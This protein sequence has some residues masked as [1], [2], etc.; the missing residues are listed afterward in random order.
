MYVEA[1]NWAHIN[2]L[3]Q[4][5]PNPTAKESNRTAEALKWLLQEI[6]NDRNIQ[7]H[8]KEV[9]ANCFTTGA[10]RP[11]RLLAYSVL[12]AAAGSHRVSWGSLF[13]P[14]MTDLSTASD[15]ELQVK[16]AQLMQLLPGEDLIEALSNHEDLFD[17]AI[18]T[19][20]DLAWRGAM[21]DALRPCLL[22]AWSC[23][24]PD[25]Q[26]TQDVIRDLWTKLISFALHD[27]DSMCTQGFKSLKA[28]FDE[29]STGK[30][31]AELEDFEANGSSG[32]IFYPLVQLATRPVQARLLTLLARARSLKRPEITSYPLTRLLILVIE[33]CPK[34][35]EFRLEIEGKVLPLAVRPS[36]TV[37]DLLLP[38][39]D[40]HELDRQIVFENCRCLQELH[41]VYPVTTEL[42]WEACNRLLVIACDTEASALLLMVKAT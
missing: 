31:R 40:V 19:T 30:L 20:D 34:V 18:K 15:P 4:N 22:K 6:S 9:E 35:G 25:S 16:A 29:C 21:L 36:Q 1:Q 10:P 3:R 27:D 33:E 14:L 26:R 32:E 38:Q 13:G 39:L 42:L 7:A 23:F 2:A 17:S 41:L 5:H 24:G 37:V 12:R 28:L 11:V 8:L